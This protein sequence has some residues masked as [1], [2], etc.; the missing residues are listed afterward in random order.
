MTIDGS[1]IVYYVTNLMYL[2]KYEDALKVIENFGVK[3]ESDLMC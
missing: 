3:L 2:G 1:L